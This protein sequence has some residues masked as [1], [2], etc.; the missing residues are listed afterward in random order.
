MEQIY[1][2]RQYENFVKLLDYLDQRSI[3]PMYS[4]KERVDADNIV[5][6]VETL[7]FLRMELEEKKNII[8]TALGCVPAQYKSLIMENIL[9]NVKFTDSRFDIA[10]VQTWKYWKNRFVWEV[11][12]LRGNEEYLELLRAVGK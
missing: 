11:A 5:N 10:H 1:F 8:D 6:P 9:R 12:R 2:I 3:T 7:A 4:E